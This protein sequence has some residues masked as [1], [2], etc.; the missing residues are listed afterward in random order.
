MDTNEVNI[1]P[2]LIEQAGRDADMLVRQIQASG[3]LEPAYAALD[4]GLAQ[5][6]ESGFPIEA[7]LPA[8]GEAGMGFAAVARTGN[9]F[10]RRYREAVR[11]SL[12]SHDGELGKAVRP[13]IQGGTGAIITAI[14]A[15]L[16]LPVVAIPVIVPLAAILVTIGLDA[17]CDG[18]NE[19]TE[20]NK[21]AG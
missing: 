14:I 18:Q 4:A 16:A 11:K 15:T 12:C 1:D 19:P 5:F 7:L 9:G 3:D 10:W 6:E 2:Q 13:V 21:I 17:F 20:I 8:D